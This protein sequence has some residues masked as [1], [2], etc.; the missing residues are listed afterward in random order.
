[1]SAARRASR[2]ALSA[3]MRRSSPSIHCATS[4]AVSNVPSPAFAWKANAGIVA[5]R[6]AG[7][8]TVDFGRAVRHAAESARTSPTYDAMPSAR[9]A[10]T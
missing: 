10:S 7:H 3:T 2:G 4:A 5:A 9:L 8:G 1:M 6:S